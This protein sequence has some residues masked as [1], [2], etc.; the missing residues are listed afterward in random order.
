MKSFTASSK[1]YKTIFEN[2]SDVILVLDKKKNVFFCSSAFNKLFGYAEKE[3]T[4]KHIRVIHPSDENYHAFEE[5]V[6]PVVKKFKS[7]RGEWDFVRKNGTTL[8]GEVALFAVNNGDS[9]PAG[10][11]AIM[12]ALINHKETEK[13]NEMKS[14]AFEEMNEALK[15]LL[16]REVEEKKFL[17]MKIQSNVKDLVLP[18]IEKLRST[19]LTAEQHTYLEIIETTIKNIFSAFLEKMTSK[20]YHFTPKEI[21]VSTLIREGKTTKQIADIMKVTRSAIGLHRHHIRN[22]MGLGKAKINLR[23]YLLSLQ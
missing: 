2:V 19:G 13:S 22:K 8:K 5:K 6:N 21:Q 1:W 16:A 12:K 11:I 4:G 10:Y 9:A 17:E 15:I 7:Y 23:S 18:Y 14:K 20:Q 3:I